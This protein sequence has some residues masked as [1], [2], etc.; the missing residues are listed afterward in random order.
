MCVKCHLL[1]IGKNKDEREW[2]NID[3]IY[4]GQVDSLVYLSSVI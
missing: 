1:Q 2:L 4:V 3:G